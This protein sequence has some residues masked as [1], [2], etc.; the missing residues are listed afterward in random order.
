M[1]IPAL[2]WTAKT[3]Y[4]SSLSI[5]SGLTAQISEQ[6]QLSSFS[7]VGNSHLMKSPAQNYS[8]MDSLF[9]IPSTFST[10]VVLVQLGTVLFLPSDP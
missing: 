1:E 3:R 2:L 5:N 7:P 10:I 8:Q 9:Q 6:L 4:S